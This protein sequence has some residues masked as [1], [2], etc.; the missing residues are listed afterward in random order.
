MMLMCLKSMGTR[1]VSM[2]GTRP[3]ACLQHPCRHCGII[4]QKLSSRA[5]GVEE[6]SSYLSPGML[7]P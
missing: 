2:L 6:G 3:E 1:S 5:N 7:L 4:D